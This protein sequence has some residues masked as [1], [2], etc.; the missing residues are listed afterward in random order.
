MNFISSSFFLRLMSV[1]VELKIIINGKDV[2]F[3]AGPSY[4]A[5]TC[6]PSAKDF[7][8]SSVIRG[9]ESSSRSSS[10]RSPVC[11]KH[12]PYYS[13]PDDGEPEP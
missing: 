7:T 6:S 4:E 8:S 13:F 12:P 11:G 9:T 1:T 3:K 2:I 5:P 10:R